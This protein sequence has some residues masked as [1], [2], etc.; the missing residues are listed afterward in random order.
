M[1]VHRLRRSLSRRSHRA[2][3]QNS[4]G[5]QRGS[6]LV[7]V[8]GI[9]VVAI[10]VAGVAWLFIRG[11]AEAG[12]GPLLHAVEQ[13]PFDHIVL[14]QG[15]VESS[16]NIEV[17]C[18]VKSRNTSGTQ[19]LWVVPEGTQ[20]KKGD[21]L[22][23]L[24]ASALE[25]ERDQQQIV[26]NTGDSVVIQARNTY[27]AALISRTE[28]LEGTYKQEEQ[29]ILGEVFVAEQNLR[30]AQLSIESAQRLLSKGIVTALQ[31]EGEQFLV[32]KARN[33]LDAAQ[34][35]LRVL[36]EYTLAKSLKQFDSDIATS[37]AKWKA[38]QSSLEL[39]KKKLEDILKQIANCEIL[40]PADGQVVY[41]NVASSRGG[42][43]EFV[44]E[45]GA[46]VREG[47]VLIRLP[48]PAQMQV[49]AKINESRVTLVRAGMPVLIRLDAF[50]AEEPVRGEV[51]KVNQYAEPGSWFSS[52]VKEYA[53]FIRIANPPDGI[54]PGLTAEVRIFVEHR[55]DAVQL[56]VQSVFEHG[57]KTYCLVKA[58][59][60][61]GK[62]E[63]RE[64]TI[65]SSNDKFVTVEDT[66]HSPNADGIK[67]GVVKGE[68]V[69]MDHR[70][71]VAKV[72]LPKVEDAPKSELP[73]GAVP[74]AAAAKSDR[75]PGAAP[76]GGGPDRRG[77][78][79][80]GPPGGG[81][82]GGP[83]GPGG[84]GPG[85]PGGGPGGPGGPGGGGGRG[86]F[87]PAAMFARLDTN[88]DGKIDS[89]ELDAIPVE[90]MRDRMKQNDTNGDGSVDREEFDAAMARRRAQGGGPGGPGGGPG[91]SGG[92]PGGFGGGAPRGGPGGGN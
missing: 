49:K 67:R 35:R 83:G 71:F 24:D 54:R 57:G 18:E 78:G 87:D 76:G 3:R 65:G 27:E 2:A 80:G 90:V 81:V 34:T 1:A 11:E 36:R 5:P 58:N 33:E 48:D 88:S 26:C 25:R 22:A 32:D 4:R 56:P 73:P 75:P 21:L 31:V 79:P 74:V 6:T 59:S 37:E 77:A 64:I 47:Q 14:E 62:L 89:G 92:G 69:V 28:Y 8:V 29:R 13:G 39:E 41:A 72:S 43:S 42:S 7:L 66:D 55:E 40:A 50:N 53:T 61:D 9:L 16:S 38:E 84:S 19:I 23:R 45:A 10:I 44:V 30:S 91:G 63:P 20:V 85:G 15:E 86:N 51:T 60:S 68:Q 82:A 17:R 12:T 70:N 46:N 52:Q